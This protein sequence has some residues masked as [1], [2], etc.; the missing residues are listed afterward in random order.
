M[1]ETPLQRRLLLRASV[2]WSRVNKNGPIIRDGLGPCW[3]WTA[4][5]TPYGYGCFDFIGGT[6]AH[7]FSW[8]LHNGSLPS[9]FVC[10]HCDNPPCIRP[11]HLF[12]G[13][14]GDNTADRD[15]KGRQK[16]KRG[17]HCA[18]AKFTYEQ[19]RQIRELYKTVRSQ[20]RLA[21]M[22]G[23]AKY[24]IHRIVRNIGYTE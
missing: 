24:T 1:S 14:Q 23:V 12:L 13:T 18:T 2:F 15:R 3:I 21:E 20:R 22:F 8:L 5:C 9:L 11:D 19:A 16:T 17:E 7:R 4:R 6:L 10:H